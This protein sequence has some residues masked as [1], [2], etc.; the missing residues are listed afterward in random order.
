MRVTR[1]VC[2]N[3]DCNKGIEMPENQR[4]ACWLLLKNARDEREIAR[5]KGITPSS[6]EVCSIDCAA[7]LLKRSSSKIHV[8]SFE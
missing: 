2:D 4:P 8:I 7:A 5:L 1:F 6:Q 3:P